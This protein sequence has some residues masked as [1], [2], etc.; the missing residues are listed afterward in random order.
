[1]INKIL[2]LLLPILLFSCKQID[3]DKSFPALKN[4]VLAFNGLAETFSL[5]EV[6]NGRVYND[7]K[8]TG[9]WPNHMTQE[10][11]KL[12]LVYSG[13]NTVSILDLDLNTIKEIYLG[14]SK[15]PWMVFPV[16]G[17]DNIYVTCFDSNEI[18]LVNTITESIESVHTGSTPQ[19]GAFNNNKLYISNTHYVEWNTFNRGTVSVI[20]VAS[21]T[22]LE[23]IDLNFNGKT[24]I[25]PQTVISMNSNEIYVV[26]SGIPGENDGN[27]FVIATT[28]NTITDVI[29]TGKS[30]VYAEGSINTTD[31]EIY[32]YGVGGLFYYNYATKTTVPF[33]EDITISDTFFSGLTYV[34]GT[35]EILVS[36]FS[37]DKVHVFSGNNFS[38]KKSYQVSDGVQQLLYIK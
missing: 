27:I 33:G 19:G 22:Y 6:S 9:I 12:F 30:P 24:G 21:S 38:Y 15:N 20:D 34:P 29:E 25:N 36:D 5:I 17:T 32:F 26:C 13:E 23:D 7:I 37:K 14:V 35:D 16:T 2:L 11:D 10:D 18:L 3:D 1:M 31:S 4:N 8:T 28:T